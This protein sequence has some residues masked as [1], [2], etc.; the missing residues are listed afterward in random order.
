MKYIFV[1]LAIKTGYKHCSKMTM[2]DYI[3]LFL[4][5]KTYTI[6]FLTGKIQSTI[7]SYKRRYTLIFRNN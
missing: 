3:S 7:K 6:F 2:A 5:I 1:Y 4:I